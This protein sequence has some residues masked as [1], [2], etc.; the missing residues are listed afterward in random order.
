M[1]NRNA[2]FDELNTNVDKIGDLLSD[3]RKQIDDMQ[4]SSDENILDNAY[5]YETEVRDEDFKNILTLY[6]PIV[7][8]KKKDPLCQK[9]KNGLIPVNNSFSNEYR[10]C[11]CIFDIPEYIV[12]EISI[13]E[14]YSDGV[15][16]SFI[17]HTKDG[18]LKINENSIKY[19]FDESNANDTMIVYYSKE[20]CQE[21]C[22]FLNLL[23]IGVQK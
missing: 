6:R 9:C 2:I 4:T 1:V 13:D 18:I 7:T 21:H 12:Q 10:T 15:T 23:T 22:D 3:M 17:S 14:K 11:D 20:S 16:T 8:F 5:Y 19:Y